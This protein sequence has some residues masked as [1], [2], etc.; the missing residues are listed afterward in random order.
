MRNLI[1]NKSKFVALNYEGKEDVVSSDGY[2]T[3]ES[4][5][6]YS[7]PIA[8]Y[9]HISGATGSSYIDSNG[10]LI[11][12]DKSF[13]LTKFEM[14]QLRF[15]ENSVFFIEKQPEFDSDGQPLYDYRVKRI[16]D[17]LNEVVILLKKVRND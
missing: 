10:V 5:I 13:V 15:N 6:V 4:K 16:K 11:E 14:E 12:Y 3:G 7:E 8:F 2:K 1:K 9:T 17:T